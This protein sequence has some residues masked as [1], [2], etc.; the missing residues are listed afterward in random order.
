MSVMLCSLLQAVEA[1]M[2]IGSILYTVCV[3]AC[4]LLIL[5]KQDNNSVIKD[6]VNVL[7]KY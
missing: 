5:E 4:A 1:P 6:L 7:R 3:C 2:L